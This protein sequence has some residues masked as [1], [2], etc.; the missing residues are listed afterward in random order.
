M[1]DIDSSGQLEINEQLQLTE[2]ENKMFDYLQEV[3]E[4]GKKNTVMRV[5]G[6]WVRDKLL[7]RESDDID[8]ALDNCMG[9]EF[10]ELVQAYN[11]TKG[12][13]TRGFSVI[14]SNPE[15]SKHLETATMK[16]EDVPVDFVNLRAEEYTD[17]RIPTMK[18]GT[19]SEDA[20]RRDL[21]INSMFYNINERKIEDITGRGINDLKNKKIRTPLLPLSTFLDDPLRVLR[22]V[23]FASRFRF[24]LDE[25]LIA[26]AKEGSVKEGLLNKVS[27]ER[28]GKEITGMFQT[29]GSSVQDKRYPVYA[30]R[31]MQ[32]LE[33]LPIIFQLPKDVVIKE[34]DFLS[35]GVDR[36]LQLQRTFH[37]VQMR[38][39]NLNA[40]IS[41]EERMHM[42]LSAFFT[43]LH[44]YKYKNNKGKYEPASRY[45]VLESVK[46]SG[47]EADMVELMTD[48]TYK[49]IRFLSNYNPPDEEG[50]YSWSTALLGDIPRK[51]LGILVRSC[52]GKHGAFYRH[53]TLLALS[54]QL[55][56]GSHDVFDDE[57]PEE[58]TK[59][60]Y[61]FYS[62]FEDRVTTLGLSDAHNLK[63][64]ING[65]DVLVHMKLP[66]GPWLSR[67]QELQLEW[68]LE[69]PEKGEEDCIRYLLSLK[70]DPEIVK[71]ID[72]GRRKKA[73]Q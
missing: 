71:L 72:E 31:L 55:P 68:Q 54:M 18:F 45:A 23:R 58:Q 11:N 34:K 43:T 24:E 59:K 48:G 28:F 37:Q 62:A 56:S 26:A 22:S 39:G 3:N 9:K 44:D 13:S 30:F 8:I 66:A 60:V 2:R 38:N 19:A 1:M 20:H 53:V 64:L 15:Q 67:V 52:S 69:N 6:G 32:E 27:R 61:D 12:I 40:E 7:G 4:F 49:M 65:K 46:L 33:L 17:S 73:R 70:E 21:T 36:M 57:L 63:H 41:H 50:K 29:S 10:A 5:A 14:Q 25:Q 42:Y 47:K 16:I 35:I 51:E